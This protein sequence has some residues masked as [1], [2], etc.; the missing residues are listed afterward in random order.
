MR[1][2]L[3]CFRVP[4]SYLVEAGSGETDWAEVASGEAEGMVSTS[5]EV[6]PCSRW[7]TPKGRLGFL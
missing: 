1:L 7:E 4:L 5:S 2:S 6:E 3:A